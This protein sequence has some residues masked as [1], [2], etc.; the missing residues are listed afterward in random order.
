MALVCFAFVQPMP[1]HPSMSQA[2]D[3]ASL[4]RS[5]PGPGQVTETP[6]FVDTVSSGKTFTPY[7]DI[8]SAPLLHHGGPQTFRQLEPVMHMP[9]APPEP[10]IRPG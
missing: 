9:T 2:K 5:S 6:P 10:L 3:R 8:S 1:D 4:E 7:L